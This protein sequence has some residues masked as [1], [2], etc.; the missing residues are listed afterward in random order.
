[1][2]VL[3]FICMYADIVLFSATGFLLCVSVSALIPVDSD[4]AALWLGAVR[5]AERDEL[6][7]PRQL[8]GNAE[9]SLLYSSLQSQLL[10]LDLWWLL[11]SEKEAV[12]RSLS[13]HVSPPQL[14][15][16]L[17]SFLNTWRLSG[18][19]CRHVSQTRGRQEGWGGTDI[20]RHAA[21]T[22]Q[23]ARA[24]L[25]RPSS[26][27]QSAWAVTRSGFGFHGT[28]EKPCGC[29]GADPALK[30]VQVSLDFES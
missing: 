11:Q 27:Y 26:A 23:S 7:R 29:E 22:T 28:G 1:M 2:F 14:N 20:W 4:A 24:P 5:G 25:R 6:P 19:E 13:V 10:Y 8:R 3:P 30:C 18:D 17:L 12:R 16:P 15:Q 21:S 9:A